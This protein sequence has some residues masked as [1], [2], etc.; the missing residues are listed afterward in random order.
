MK[1]YTFDTRAR[2]LP[3]EMH[4]GIARVMTRIGRA[5]PTDDLVVAV[6][7]R[8]GKDWYAHAGVEWVARDRFAHAGGRWAFVKRFP[9]PPDLPE[10]FKLIRIAMGS[11]ISYPDTMSDRYGWQIRCA[12]FEDHLAYVFAHELHHFRRYHLDLHPREGEQAAC[13]W[14]LERA[15]DAGFAAEGCRVANA[16]S[17]PRRKKVDLPD[18]RRPQLLRRIKESASRLSLD[19]LRELG[20]W[21]RSRAQAAGHQAVRGKWDDHFDA[22]RALP[23]G[24]SVVIVGDDDRQRYLG[25]RAVKIRNLRR[26]SPRLAVRTSDGKEWHW[27]MRWLSAPPSAE[28]SENHDV[29]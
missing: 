14:A 18:G 6:Y 27:P 20:R 11:A 22:L 12:T 7:Q 23:F 25:Q 8:R 3:S 9:I 19:D 1:V 4:E 16:G 24:T 15:K 10:R 29:T 2:V 26:N 21:A 28:A 17:K 5:T 13:R